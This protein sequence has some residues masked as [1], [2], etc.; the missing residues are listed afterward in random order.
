MNKIE[1]ELDD[2]EY[3]LL[4]VVADRELRTVENLVARMI[5]TVTEQEY[6]QQEAESG[7]YEERA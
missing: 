5:R 4:G 1:V 2:R 7:V 6:Y 3:E